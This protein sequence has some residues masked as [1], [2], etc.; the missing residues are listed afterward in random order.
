[1][2]IKKWKLLLWGNP[3]LS[4]HCLKQNCLLNEALHSQRF[5]WMPGPG[6]LISHLCWNMMA[7]IVLL[8][9]TICAKSAPDM[10]NQ[11]PIW[12][13]HSADGSQISAHSQANTSLNELWNIFII[14]WTVAHSLAA[15][16]VI[17]EMT[18]WQIG[19]FSLKL[20]TVGKTSVLQIRNWHKCRCSWWGHGLWWDHL[21]SILSQLKKFLLGKPQWL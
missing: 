11:K 20:Y 3:Y 14:S 12:S 5:P 21:E 1:M 15:W 17:W 19:D 4:L 8:W 7:C 6:S 9:K 16:S 18:H 2:C 10:H 13:F